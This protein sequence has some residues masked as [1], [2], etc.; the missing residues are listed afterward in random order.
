MKI[1]GYLL[2]LLN[3]AAT[4]AFIY[5]ATGVWQRRSAWQYALF[6]QE[7][8][9]RGLPLEQPPKADDL[10]EGFVAF[11]FRYDQS[12]VTQISKNKLKALIPAGGDFLGNKGDP[13][14]SLTE[15]VI[16]V[17]KIIFDDLAKVSDIEEKRQRQMVL[18]V[19]LA[20]GFGREGA[21]ALLRDFPIDNRRAA[22]RREM[23][24]L[25]RTSP[26]V[27]ALLAL[28]AVGEAN[29]GYQPNI[30]PILKATRIR[31]GRKALIVWALSEVQY[32]TPD[33]LP[34][35]VEPK[36]TD[37]TPATPPVNANK[38]RLNDALI[39]IQPEMEAEMP[40][41]DGI[42]T[43][44]ERLTALLEGEDPISGEKAGIL[45]PF[46]RDIGTNLLDSPE[47][48]AAAKEKLLELLLMRATTEAEKKS[49]R[50]TADL[51]MPPA[52][53][54][55]QTEKDQRDQNIDI[56]ASELLRSYFEE[57][58]AK[59]ST[60]EQASEARNKLAFTG[61]M[62]GPEHKRRQIAHLLYHLDAH[63]GY[64]SGARWI[65]YGYFILQ[66]PRDPAAEPPEDEVL[67][68][69]PPDEIFAKNRTEW[70]KRV[71]AVVGLESYVP[72]IEEQASQLYDLRQRVN[73]RI[74]EEQT[75]FENE[76][77]GVIL[78]TLYLAA[79]LELRKPEVVRNERLR[80]EQKAITRER[81]VERDKFDSDLK[82]ITSK[83]K[84]A[85]EKLDLKVQELF[86]ITQKLGDAQ[87]ALIGLEV[88]LREMQLGRADKK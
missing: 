66:Q 82:D 9:N 53:E 20:R 1:W 62:R 13:V 7:L 79:Q 35:T 28:A 85:T 6:K 52:R 34:P 17:E 18:L 46:I 72:I 32:A 49:L 26:Q 43:G 40:N 10:E 45:I 69:N 31:D 3:I 81:K 24:Y 64:G 65:W 61:P 19:N 22:A 55:N 2:I 84:I 58:S 41:V 12:F 68:L 71:A 77:Q 4:G 86:E 76:Y 11:D 75:H 80:D 73:G 14:T 57:A 39:A 51:M 63:V 42:K 15:E 48:V 59:L 30:D 87:D 37:D 33:E 47:N 27:S 25:G 70:H 29:T 44:R 16:R 60:D 50:A 8:V 23:A 5:F 83:A 74:K 38:T 67:T 54:E 56:A 36:R 88:R 21:Y 78:Q